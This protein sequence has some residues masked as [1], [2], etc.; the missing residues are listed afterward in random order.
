MW[1]LTRR[2]PDDESLI[3]HL[4]GELRG[5]AENRLAT[6][7]RSCW[8]CR[9]RLSQ[10]E[11]GI[12]EL[13]RARQAAVFPGKQRIEA[14]RQAFLERFEVL[15]SQMAAEEGG[16]GASRRR[17]QR[18]TWATAAAAA[19]VGGVALWVRP[20]APGAPAVLRAT[21][22]CETALFQSAW[23]VHQVFRVEATGTGGRRDV[24]RLEVW[25]D[26]HAR[27]FTSRWDD[28]AGVVR[29]AMW[30]G[31][32]AA[33][34]PVYLVD[35]PQESLEQFQDS[36]LRWLKATRW[37]PVSLSGEF[38]HFAGEQGARL[39]VRRAGGRLVLEVR[40]GAAA[41]ILEVDEA[42]HRPLSLTLRQ[43][44]AG[45]ILAVRMTGELMEA[46]NPSLVPEAAFRPDAGAPRVGSAPAAPPRP[47]APPPLPAAAALDTAEVRALYA[48][49][50]ARSCL[51]EPL[52]LVRE[53][54]GIQ[55]RGQV[56][57]RQRRQQLRDALAGIPLVSVRVQSPDE[58]SQVRGRRAVTGAVEIRVEKSAISDRLQ[59]FLSR[60]DPSDAPNRAVE[61]SD[62]AVTNAQAALNQAW[63]LRRLAEWASPDKEGRLAV[64][65][66][67]LLA[68]M[69]RD[70]AAA[71]RGELAQQTSLLKPVLTSAGARWAAAHS[72]ETLAP[73][74]QPAALQLFEASREIEGL[75]AT[76]FARSG[77]DPK[78][79]DQEVQALL[80]ALAEA[81]DRV[82]ALDGRLAVAFR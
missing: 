71:L 34:A 53:A 68:A 76:L 4:D 70:H 15:A 44:R 35:L 7:V 30:R 46:V 69:V 80:A 45:R 79:T 1:N 8:Q 6:H 50:E 31:T 75:T 22:A 11:E 63:A 27:R 14:S 36:F 3:A 39:V 55:V 72:S 77:D 25:S 33:A 12:G 24:S 18:W 54:A 5:K 81:R 10:M 41:A 16:G 65:S 23:P 57:T 26:A 42:S 40:R 73:G 59:Q 28:A 62:K 49:H 47:L 43:E 64:D 74:W 37:Q 82:E 38:A 32:D 17:P 21:Q 51:G 56:G 9:T 19:L 48:L 52:E 61:L 66:R 20:V 29:C 67:R 13:T 60:E 58:P 2:H 78:K